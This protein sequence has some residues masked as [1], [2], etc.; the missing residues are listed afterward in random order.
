MMADE[1]LA[2]G[3]H[4]IA[5]ARVVDAAVVS[6]GGT[7]Y[8][9][10]VLAVE[11][12]VLGAVAGERMRVRVLGGTLPDGTGLRI[13]GTPELAVD[14]SVIAFLVRNERGEWAFEQLALGAFRIGH[15][16]DGREVAVRDLVGATEAQMDTPHRRMRAES[17][18]QAHLPRDAAAFTAW[19]RERVGG[20]DR[21]PDYFLTEK[22]R[23]VQ[24]ARQA[25][26]LLADPGTGRNIHWTEFTSP[27]N[28]VTWHM[29]RKGQKGLGKKGQNAVKAAL[30]A[31]SKIFNV[32]L[33]YGG[34][35]KAKA[36]FTT[37]DGINTLAF[38]DPANNIPG[39]FNCSSG[40][41]LAIGGPWYNAS[42]LDGAFIVAL[43][44]DVVFQDNLR[45][46]FQ[47]SPARTAGPN[48]RKGDKAAE[49]VAAHEL[50]HTLG[51]GH[52]C[53]S[54]ELPC[55]KAKFDKALMRWAVHNDGRG[56]KIQNDDKKG[57]KKL[58]YK[59][60]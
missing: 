14:Q 31:W 35:N 28:S 2:D 10:Y 6:V 17:L 57:I 39:S 7:P 27:G 49:E 36:A 3:A 33:A 32:R 15:T 29:Y 40:G 25:F 9:E 46:F 38:N 24:D 42:V 1:D 53:E 4:A 54:P 13:W 55:N 16:Q 23:P 47:A 56:A 5:R 8:T 51:L 52:S 43:G 60:S 44:A 41:V 34:K 19:L 20:A 37:F 30:A 26:S 48:F 21:A 11:E 59:G 18:R 12:E 45:C 58:G 22:D 50:G